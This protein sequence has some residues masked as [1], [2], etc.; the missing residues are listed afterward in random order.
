MKED[1]KLLFRENENGVS[2]RMML[3]GEKLSLRF[4]VRVE[5]LIIMVLLFLKE[6]LG[7]AFWTLNN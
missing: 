2:M 4:M 6:P 7:E 1:E 3:Y 5:V